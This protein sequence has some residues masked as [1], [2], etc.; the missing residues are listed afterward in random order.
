[1]FGDTSLASDDTVVEHWRSSMSALDTT[2]GDAAYQVIHRG[3][4]YEE[5]HGV[6]VPV[7]AIAGDEDHAYPQPISGRNIA[8]AT[9]GREETVPRAGHSVALEQ[10]EIVAQLLLTHLEQS[11]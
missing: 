2:I 5:L 9:G 1:M 10:P 7:L 3:R 8:A 6:T 4:I 11:P